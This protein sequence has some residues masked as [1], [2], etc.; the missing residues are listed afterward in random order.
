[1][2]SSDVLLFDMKKKASSYNG[3]YSKYNTVSS[4]YWKQWF[5][6]FFK[7][8]YAYINFKSTCL[9]GTH[10]IYWSK[11]LLSHSIIDNNMKFTVIMLD[12][13][14]VLFLNLFVGFYSIS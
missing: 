1:M 6:W 2:I 13:W 4:I 7:S 8:G 14:L 9:N 5:K 11:S 3:I 12:H 10:K